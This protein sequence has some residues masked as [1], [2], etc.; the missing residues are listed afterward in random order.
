M[1]SIIVVFFK[2]FLLVCFCLYC[3]FQILQGFPIVISSSSQ[4][5]AS[6]LTHSED[7]YCE[8]MELYYGL[9]PFSVKK[10]EL[11]AV[12]KK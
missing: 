6:T 3:L 7:G 4:R 11:C 8:F 12:H 1:F 5:I 9:V 10:A 2:S